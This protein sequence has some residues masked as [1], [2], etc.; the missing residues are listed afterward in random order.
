MPTSPL[1]AGESFTVRQVTTTDEA[2]VQAFLTAC[3]DYAVMLTGKPHDSDAAAQV[4]AAL[5]PDKT[6]ADKFVLAIEAPDRPL[7]GL[8]DAIKD[9]P[10]PG[11]WFLGLLLLHPDARSQGLGEK[12]YAAFAEW[13]FAQGGDIVRLGVV[14]QNERALAFWT[15]AGFQEV[16]RQPMRFAD[17]ETEAVILQDVLV[18]DPEPA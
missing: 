15:K 11:V 7:I 5:P 16:A 13:V 12:V 18:A 17:K 6:A 14:K 8:I 9:Y 4:F 2:G 3:D 10:E 1:F